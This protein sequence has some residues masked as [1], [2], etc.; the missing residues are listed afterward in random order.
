MAMQKLIEYRI[1]IDEKVTGGL[2]LPETMILYAVDTEHMI[3]T[4]K[5]NKTL[6]EKAITKTEVKVIVGK[7]RHIILIPTKIYNFY[8]LE[9]SDYTV[10]VSDKD[11]ATIMIAV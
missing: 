8:R 5:P 3:L 1:E 10:M 6:E 2:K 7:N 4:A 11:P 9:E